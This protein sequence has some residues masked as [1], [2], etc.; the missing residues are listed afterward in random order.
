MGGED[1][2]FYGEKV[3]ACFCVLGQQA[4]GGVMPGSHSPRYG[5]SDRRSD[6]DPVGDTCVDG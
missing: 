2:S 3:P 4:E 5:F 6:R 1:F